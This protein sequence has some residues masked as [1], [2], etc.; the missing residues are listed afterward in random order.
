VPGEA[1]SQIEA[2]LVAGSLEHPDGRATAWTVV[3]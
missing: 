1:R 2:A 3:G